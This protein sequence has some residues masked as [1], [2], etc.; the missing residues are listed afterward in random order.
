MSDS[1]LPVRLDAARK[2]LAECR[3]DFERLQLRDEVKAVKAAAEILGRRDI[4]VEAT[5]FI[6]EAERAIHKANPPFGRGKGRP[7][8]DE[9]KSVVSDDAFSASTLRDIRQAHKALTDQGF[10]DICEAARQDQRP[11]TRTFLRSVGK[12]HVASNSGQNEWYT[13]PEYIEAARAVM[14]G[15]DLDPASSDIANERVKAA[16]YF[17]AEDDGLAQE[18]SGRVWMNPPYAKKLIEPFIEKIVKSEIDQAV[19]LVNNGTDSK[20]GQKLLIASNAVCFPSGR[21]RF[22]SPSG[23]RGAAPLQGQ[24][25]GGIR[26]NL[27]RFQ[28]QFG[29][30]GAIL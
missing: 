4:V 13:P 2:A 30:F 6:S 24:M 1:T 29:K 22:M 10:A 17:T 12:A 18:W 9:K 27:S 5:I 20:W 16:R 8:T 15:I 11:V 23:E 25:I 19:V 3:T 14:G 7:K 21:I 28:E 26:V